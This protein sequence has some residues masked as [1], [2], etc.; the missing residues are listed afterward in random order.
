L[1]QGL[2]VIVAHCAS[3][4]KSLDLDAAGHRQATSFSLFMRLL[5]D[6]SF[7]GRLFGDVSAIT[8]PNR[9]PGVL[10]RLL[11]REEL[12]PRLVY[13]S[14]YPIPAVNVL[15]PSAPLVAAGFLTRRQARALREIFAANP[16]LFDL[17]LKRTIRAPRGGPGFPASL[18][19]AH[20]D[21][22]VGSGAR[23]APA[24]PHLT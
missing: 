19:S 21:L 3:A 6:P 9:F 24:E 7:E 12:H 4:G 23:P 8:V 1:E 18:F 5:E 14:D 13:G 10:A 22:P 16:L 2:R 20:P 17:V 11:A 15:M